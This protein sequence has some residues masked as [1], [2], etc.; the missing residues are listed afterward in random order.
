MTHTNEL[1]LPAIEVRQGP[2]HLLYTFAI[3]GKLI[4]SFS[5][6]SRIHRNGEKRIEGYQRPEV[7]SHI[8]EIK[9]YLDSNAPMIPNAV[10]IAFDSR[11][12]FE[13]SGEGKDPKAYTRIGAIVIPIDDD[14]AAEN[15]PGFIVDGQ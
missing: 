12:R 10:V 13:C 2:E 8:A 5:T 7:L 3:D 6:I 15:K 9:N 14:V 11:V 1:R 4:P